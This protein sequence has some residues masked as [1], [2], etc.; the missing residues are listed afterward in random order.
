MWYKRAALRSL[1]EQQV[2]PSPLIYNI[3]EDNISPETFSKF[4]QLSLD[5]GT[6]HFLDNFCAQEEGILITMMGNLLR[7]Y[8]S[9]TDSNAILNRGQMHVLSANQ[10][11]KLLTQNG[12][13]LLPKCATLLDIGAGDGNVTKNFKDVLTYFPIT[14][15]DPE[16]K[17]QIVATELSYYMVKRLEKQGFPCVETTTITRENLLPHLRKESK[18]LPS[19]PAFDL[20]SL[21][22]V[23]DRCDKPLTLLND[24]K[25]L[26]LPI[27][28]S[29]I[30][31]RGI[32]LLA[33]VFPWGPF[34]ES[35]NGQKKPSES[36]PVRGNK[37]SWPLTKKEMTSEEYNK[38]FLK[39][40][41]TLDADCT[42]T[43]KIKDLCA[44][45]GTFEDCVEWFIWNVLI[46]GG[47]EILQWT[48]VPY[49]S[50]GDMNCRY[51][52]LHNAVFVLTPSLL[53]E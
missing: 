31:K 24:I 11:Q 48:R 12:N 14:L 26:L 20:V 34:V 33:V 15:D 52:A 45:C 17:N 41:Q 42:P 49:I 2:E 9:L 1:E 4:I 5:E 29:E 53:P 10:I 46:P 51:Y 38:R 39:E 6:Q 36:L 7:Y 25:Q 8:Y 16:W 43:F 13:F 22:N 50:A 3:Q 32:L 27:E 40:S 47:W 28:E 30:R 18:P 37:V 35:G 19:D 44:C 23:I 21:L